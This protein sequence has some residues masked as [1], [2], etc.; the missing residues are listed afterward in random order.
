MGPVLAAVL[1]GAGINLDIEVYGLYDQVSGSV[2]GLAGEDELVWEDP[3]GAE[4]LRI[5][6]RPGPGG[7]TR[8]VFPPARAR[9]GTNVLRLESG[10][11]ASFTVRRDPLFSACPPPSAPCAFPFRIGPE[12]LRLRPLL[13][14]VGFRLLRRPA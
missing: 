6:L 8:F 12:L 1:F 13:P 11:R 3:E 9:S 2:D 7:K 10:A 4:F 14:V 5:G